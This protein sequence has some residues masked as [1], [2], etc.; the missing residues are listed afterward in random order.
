LR[1][2]TFFAELSE[3][4]KTWASPLKELLLEMKAEVE[5]AGAEGGRPVADAKLA[6]LTGTYDRLIAEGLEAQPPPEVPEPVRRQARN[7]LRRLERRKG[8]VL[9]F[10][11]D[12]TVPFDN[13]QAERDLRMVKLQQKVGGCF[14]SEEGARRF[15]RIRSYLS[16]MR[17][18]GRNVLL[19]L[20]GA[21]TGEPLSLRKCRI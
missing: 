4:T 13:N 12:F 18:H 7:L 11:T 8:E 10:L 9:L 1:E 14:R 5:R 20:E 19:A 3:E 17:K 21:C 15:C 16:T 6:E 2:L